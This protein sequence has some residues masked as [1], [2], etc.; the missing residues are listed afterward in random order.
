MRGAPDYDG[1][2]CRAPEDEHARELPLLSPHPVPPSLVAELREAKWGRHAGLGCWMCGEY[3]PSDITCSEAC[4]RE[5]LGSEEW[6]ALERSQA[7][8]D[9]IAEAEQWQTRR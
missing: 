8:D 9:E 2:R 7:V 4:E 6:R 5:L 1:W 3:S